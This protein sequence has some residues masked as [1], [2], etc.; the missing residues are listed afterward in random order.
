[1]PRKWRGHVDDARVVDA[2]LHDRVHLHRQAD[3]RRGVD[4]L[5]HARD[6]E[7]D[8]V[9]R[10]EGRV[11][12]RVEAHVDAVEPRVAQRLRLPREERRVRR[13][14]QVEAVDRREP[15]DEALELLAEQR[16]AA[17][18]A[19]L[20][21]AERDERARD[22]LELLEAQQLLAVHEPV[23]V[24]EDRLRHAVGAAEVAA[25]GD[26]DA[27]VADRAAERVERVHTHSVRNVRIARVRALDVVLPE[28]DHNEVHAIELDADPER[29]VASFLA[30]PAAPGPA[31]GDAVP[32]ARWSARGRRSRAC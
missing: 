28:F 29:A 12:E 1:M 16:L 5:E 8:V 9:H 31:R 3:R 15:L 17:G 27:Q 24:A 10:A 19:D 11:V 18:E 4:A 22:A 25:V 20:L 30:A 32:A 7:V 6:R 23:V 2:A 26:R 13:Q 14:R 21:D